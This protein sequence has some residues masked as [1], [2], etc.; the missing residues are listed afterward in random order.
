MQKG[1]DQLPQVENLPDTPTDH[2]SEFVS[3]S[4]TSQSL[5]LVKSRSSR[6][7]MCWRA[8]SC[9]VSVES[10]GSMENPAS[11]GRSLLLVILCCTFH[12]K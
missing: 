2:G 1:E 3:R 5:Q 8:V 11:R 7:S 6:R 9:F 10:N 4:L 12:S